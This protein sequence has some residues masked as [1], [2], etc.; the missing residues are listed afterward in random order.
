MVT[1]NYLSILID[2]LQAGQA[3]VQLKANT[4]VNDYNDI[5]EGF[6]IEIAVDL[7]A[8]GYP[9]GRGDGVLFISATLFDGDAFA[10]T[11]DD[12]GTRTWWMRESSVAA[13]PAWA[14]MDP[15]TL[16]PGG[17]VAIE[18][19]NNV[20]PTT[21]KII[22]NY[23]NPFNPSTNI[24]YSLP[25]DGMVTLKVYNIR[26]QILTV[27]QLGFQQAGIKTVTFNAHNLG[28]GMYFYQLQFSS[29]T[30]DNMFTATNKM[31]VIK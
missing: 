23:P 10:N 21:F 5:D 12:Y 3:A 4:T 15:A 26:G 16:V 27:Q 7:K 17:N 30:G 24:F 28:T 31:L 22:N 25:A 20:Q 11:A 9:A 19:N 1:D 29:K 2:S 18:E 6:N 13:A 14:Y 8:M